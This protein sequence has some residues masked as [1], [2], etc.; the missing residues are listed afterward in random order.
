MSTYRFATYGAT[1]KLIASLELL[2]NPIFLL[3]RV[4]MR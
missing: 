4:T 1:P 2:T 3:E